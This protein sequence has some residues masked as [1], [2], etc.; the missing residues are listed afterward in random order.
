MNINKIVRP[1]R[2]ANVDL[3]LL[4]GPLRN[5]D[6]EVFQMDILRSR[7]HECVRIWPGAGEN[8][9]D[10]SSVDPGLRQLVLLVKEPVRTFQQHV[11]KARMSN[12]RILPPT[13]RPGERI[14]ENSDTYWVVERRTDGALR[15]FLCGMDE[16]HLFVAQ[17]GEGETV[18]EAHASLRPGE[19]DAAERRAP[20][21]TVRQGEWFFLPLE[22]G[23]RE[24]L[25][26]YIRETSRAIVSKSP[27]GPGMRP[28]VAE[29]LVHR[30]EQSGFTRRRHRGFVRTRTYAR[31]AVRH[32]DHQTVRLNGWRRVV[33]NRE[34]TASQIGDNGVYWFD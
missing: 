16:S 13:L 28:H 29:E 30:I 34:I 15:R 17:F 21:E 4:R 22:A 12:G 14:I 27:V 18:R 32:P 9:V 20:G 23:E 11:D 1:F 19:V 24:G 3:R 10:V 7:V 33:R 31:G 5:V 2:E 6:R 26:I 8:R 25:E